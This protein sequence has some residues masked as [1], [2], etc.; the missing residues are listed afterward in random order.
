MKINYV[1]CHFLATRLTIMACAKLR[2]LETAYEGLRSVHVVIT[3][4]CSWALANR[5]TVVQGIARCGWPGGSCKGTESMAE[6]F[7]SRFSLKEALM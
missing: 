7:V 4:D 3:G 6:S 5:S 2:A 1:D